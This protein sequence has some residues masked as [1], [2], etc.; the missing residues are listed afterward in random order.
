MLQLAAGPPFSAGGTV[1]GEPLAYRHR[2]GALLLGCSI[3][4]LFLNSSLLLGK[5]SETVVV[6][7]DAPQDRPAVLVRHLVGN[8]ASFLCT[9]APMPR[10][11]KSNFLQGITSISGRDAQAI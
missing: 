1:R 9:E 5:L 2:L 11:P 10:V 7:G 6:V 4:L 8:R 3:V